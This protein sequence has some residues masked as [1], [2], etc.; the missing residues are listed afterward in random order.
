MLSDKQKALATHL[1][2][3]RGQTNRDAI[4]NVQDLD[5]DNIEREEAGV[6]DCGSRVFSVYTDTEADEEVIEYI[7]DSLW[8]F[9]ASFLSSYT[10]LPLEV[11]EALQPQCENANEAILCIIEKNGSIEDFA[12]E[13]ISIDGRGHFLSGW[14]GVEYEYYINGEYYYVYEN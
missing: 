1:V 13:A 11:F 3:E 4:E 8:A 10:N 7:K 5:P 9:N 6:R 2:K 14:D 12:Q